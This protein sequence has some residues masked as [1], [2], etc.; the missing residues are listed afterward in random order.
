M[1]DKGI[2]YLKRKLDTKS[3]RVNIRYNFYD[4]KYSVQEISGIIPAQL[5]YI[6]YSL[7]WCGTAVDAIA[8]RLLF[9][10]FT[11]DDFMLNEIFRL[12]S[13]DILF[14]S[15]NLSALISSCSFIYIGRDAAGYPRL[16]VIDGGS[17]TGVIDPVTNMLTEGYAVLERDENRN[18]TLEAYFRPHLTEYYKNGSRMDALTLEHKAPYALLV[19]VIYRPDAKR[20]FGHSRISRSC[21]S[22][23]QAVV[24]TLRRSEVSAEFY[25]FPQRY[26][27]GLSEDADK[28][29][30][31]KAIM[32]AF[33][34]FRKDE[35][36]DK[37]TVGQFEQQ[38][39]APFT[40]QVRMLASVFAGET[41]L[42]LDDLGFATENP[43]SEGAIRASHENLRLTARRAQQTFGVGYLNAGYLAACVRDDYEYKRQAFA[44]TLP[45]WLPIFEPDAQGLASIGDAILKVNQASEGFLGARNI[46]ALTGLES[47]AE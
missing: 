3:V 25:S 9:D 15:A 14:G 35:D 37:P 12:N 22:I 27:L 21:M 43:S 28:V 42:T 23:V 31:A 18:P 13:R 38:S 39:M 30:S 17:A 6:A 16:Q 2:A 5:R 24:R 19:P 44:D 1:M 10:R 29:D 4:M 40:E 45:T 26:A 47:D 20:P 7:G 33:L 36:G 46:R 41:G 8:D 11:H 32:S 34:D